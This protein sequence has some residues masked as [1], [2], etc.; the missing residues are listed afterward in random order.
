MYTETW[1]GRKE[2]KEGNFSVHIEVVVAFRLLSPIARR[3]EHWP[4][5]RDEISRQINVG[6]TNVRNK[7]WRGSIVRL[8]PCTSEADAEPAIPNLL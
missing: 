1:D 6:R 5:C 2:A 7:M 8:R 3:T 4:A